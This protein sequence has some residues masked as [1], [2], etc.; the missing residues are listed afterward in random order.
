VVKAVRKATTPVKGEP[1]AALQAD[2]AVAALVGD[3]PLPTQVV[4]HGDV[5]LLAGDPAARCWVEGGG[6]V[7]A[8][9]VAEACCTSPVMVMAHD[10]DGPVAVTE[11]RRLFTATQRAAMAARD[12]AWC[13]FPGCDVV[14]GLEA[15]HVLAHGRRG[16]TTV[17]NGALLC[18]S[19]H[20][21][22]H[23]NE[24][25]LRR[26][27][28][29]AYDVVHHDGRPWRTTPIIDPTLLEPD[30]S[31]NPRSQWWGGTFDYDHVLTALGSLRPIT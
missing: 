31:G 2:T 7:A 26:I 4:L 16:A 1:L 13:S 22:L 18:P 9:V 12:G 15:H 10:D 21:F 20:R 28:P 17:A 27:R 19:H 29:G 30:P 6:A 25:A 8:A 14:H 23:R 3:G 11:S 24:L 5:S